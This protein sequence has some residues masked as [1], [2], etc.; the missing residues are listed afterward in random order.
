MTQRKSGLG[1]RIERFFLSNPDEELTYVQ[2]AAKFDCT[3]C[4]ARWAVKELIKRKDIESVH[5]IR[6]RSKGIAE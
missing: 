3:V 2:I 6:S 1:V 5:V 4:A